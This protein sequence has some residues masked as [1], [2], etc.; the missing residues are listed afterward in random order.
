MVLLNLAVDQGIALGVQVRLE[1]TSP[2]VSDVLFFNLSD[3]EVMAGL[4][5]LLVESRP[6]QLD[7]VSESSQV[8][9]VN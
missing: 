1:L 8:W 7:P 3:F 5:E 4:V 9:V 2:L 6:E